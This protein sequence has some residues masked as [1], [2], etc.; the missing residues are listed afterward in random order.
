LIV[1]DKRQRKQAEAIVTRVELQPEA[2]NRV[3]RY[4]VLFRNPVLVAYQGDEIKLN[5]CGIALR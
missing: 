1:L 3:P 4:N 5:R 2:A